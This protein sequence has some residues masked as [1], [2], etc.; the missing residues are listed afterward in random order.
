MELR[1]C[2]NP[3]LLLGHLP[4]PPPVLNN[5]LAAVVGAPV[6]LKTKDGGEAQVELGCIHHVF[7]GDK[8][9]YKSNDKPMEFF[10]NIEGFV[11]AE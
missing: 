5:W 10:R 9:A 1:C 6:V 3:G 11:E 8:L 4:D 2:C 7:G